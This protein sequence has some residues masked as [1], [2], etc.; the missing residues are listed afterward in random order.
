MILLTAQGSE[1]TAV[2]AM[3]A[4]AYDYLTKPFHVDEVRL[5]VARAAE[6]RRLRRR[7]RDLSIE[8]LLGRPIV[9]TSAGVRARCS[10]RRTAWA[11]GT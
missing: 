9:G 6:A 8:R 10:R 7:S 1:R 3:K 11:R 2:Q 4:G 5:A